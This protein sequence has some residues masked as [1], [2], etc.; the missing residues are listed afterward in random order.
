[1]IIRCFLCAR[2]NANL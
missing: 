2:M 1:S